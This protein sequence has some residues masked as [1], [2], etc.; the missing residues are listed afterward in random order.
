MEESGK[1]VIITTKQKI[2]IIEIWH[3]SKKV[4]GEMRGWQS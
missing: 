3:G 1:L 4:Q 2:R